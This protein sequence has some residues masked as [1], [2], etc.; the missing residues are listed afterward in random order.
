[1]RLHNRQIKATFWNDPDLLQW[2]RDKRW[3][4][5][6]LVQLADDSGCLE[7]SPFAFKLNIF[8]SPLD[9][10]ITTDRLI[11]WCDEMIKQKKLIRYEVN[12]KQ[13]LF[14]VNFH[15]HQNLKTPS[16]P[17]VPLPK[18]IA[19]Q[20]YPSNKNSGKY[21][22]NNDLLIE[23]LQSSYE[24]LTTVFQP[25][26]EP[27]LKPK[28]ELEPEP[29]LYSSADNA[30]EEEK[31]EHQADD[32][33]LDPDDLPID[34]QPRSC[35]PKTLDFIE[36]KWARTIGQIH[37]DELFQRVDELS[38][39]GSPD[40]D[41]LAIEAV[42]RA[43][44][45]GVRTVPY[46]VGILDDWISKGLMNLDQVK[47]DDER[48]KQ[49]AKKKGEKARDQNRGSSGTNAPAQSGQS[50]KYRTTQYINGQKVEG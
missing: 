33:T 40:P 28:P 34:E 3:F 43:E 1:M 39:R 2:V 19:W 17:I 36:K 5:S 25:E 4:Y 42:I 22:L 45:N 7:D 20:P 23:V 46:I 35:G 49:Q 13:C 12:K 10:D 8:P 30:H 41:A 38:I 48:H 24:V 47:E 27:E 32:W 50:S 37:R 44:S 18:W 9:D 15:K 26:P 14:I 16:P 31:K 29:E 6:G 11:T 21:V